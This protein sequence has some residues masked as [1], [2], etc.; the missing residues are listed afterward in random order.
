VAGIALHAVEPATVNRDD[1]TLHVDEIILTQL[2][3]FLSSNK[4]YATIHS[5]RTA[6]STRLASDS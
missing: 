5:A 4:H 3:A 1:C 2:L 6:S